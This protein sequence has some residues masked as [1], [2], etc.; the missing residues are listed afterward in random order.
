[1]LRGLVDSEK[2]IRDSNIRRGKTRIDIILSLDKN[3]VE[4]IKINGLTAKQKP[5]TVM[6]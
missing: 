1:M 2:S 6:I 4:D 5:A 3:T